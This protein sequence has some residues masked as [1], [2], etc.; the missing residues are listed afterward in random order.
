MPRFF[1]VGWPRRN[2]RWAR[3]P[4]CWS[5]P[6]APRRE[7]HLLVHG[8]IETLPAGP[9]GTILIN[10]LRNAIEAIE[11]SGAS[12]GCV[13]ITVAA[14]DGWVQITV[15]DSGPGLSSSAGSS[16]SGHGLGLAICRHVAESLGGR[17][18]LSM[19]PGSPG[20]RLRAD[21]P[22]SRLEGA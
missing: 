21:I 1:A 5:A 17:V 14:R 16:E 13:E 4:A 12:G 7:L 18:E 19:V 11:R 8:D 2:R 10:G 9:L 22:A 3:W 15:V 20:A 6:C